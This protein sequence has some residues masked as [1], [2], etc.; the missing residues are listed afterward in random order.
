MWI[1]LMSGDLVKIGSDVRRGMGVS[2]TININEREINGVLK[3]RNS[4]SLSYSS[5]TRFGRRGLPG[6]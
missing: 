5:D 1:A 4:S 3:G 2:M 6:E